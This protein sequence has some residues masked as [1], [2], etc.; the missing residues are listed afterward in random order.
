VVQAAGGLLLVYFA[1]SAVSEWRKQR[2]GTA[3][4]AASAP[5]TM[6]QA[7]AV[8]LLNPNPYLGWSLVL[9]PLLLKAWHEAPVNVVALLVAFYGTMVAALAAIIVLFGTVR[10][11]GPRVIRVLLLLSAV[12]LLALGLFQLWAAAPTIL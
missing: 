7:A 2:R 5:R 4:A 3:A 8:N 1:A 6:L 10:S 12:T 11:L 9:G